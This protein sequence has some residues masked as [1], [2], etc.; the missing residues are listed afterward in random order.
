MKLFKS[1][2]FKL[3]WPKFLSIFLFILLF[4]AYINIFGFFTPGETL[5]PTCLPGVPG[6][7]VQISS[8]DLSDSVNLARLDTVN[9]FSKT[10]NLRAGSTAAGTA[11]LKF[12]SGS[13]LS[14][15]EA[16][17]IEFDGNHLYLSM[18][19]GG[20]R[21]QLDQQSGAESMVYPSPGIPVSTGAA[22]AASS[23]TDNSTNWNTAYSQTR[24]WDGGNT[25]LVPATGRT[26]LGLGTAALSAIGD[27]VS[28][29]TFGTAAGSD[30][31]AF[32]TSAQGTLANSAVQG[33]P[34]TSVGYLTSLTGAV[35]TSDIGT[36]VLA[37]RTFGS[38]AGSDIGAF[39][40]SAQGT[41][42]NSAVQGTP[43]TSE[44]YYIGD[45][46][47]FATSAQGSLANTALQSLSGA[48]LLNGN[49]NGAKK[50]LGSIDN[51][52][53]GFITNNTERLT[54]LASG[55][56]GIG[57][58]TPDSNLSI[59]T[60]GNTSVQIGFADSRGVIGY[61][62]S[63]GA[64]G[65]MYIGTGNNNGPLLLNPVGKGNVGIGTTTPTAVLQLN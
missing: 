52:D 24:Q 58:T 9:S 60:G 61:D 25:G 13:L 45:G 33:T 7:T 27:F 51:Y 54:V 46:S 3:H 31:G 55:N 23:I 59:G 41:L 18:A 8:T 19:N 44:G 35:L 1:Q 14:M 12:T 42:A 38:A 37:Q 17:S 28:Y 50:T 49:T 15:T 26:S 57:T 32:A 36:T 47:A 34:W 20:P 10:I 64:A 65:G 16:G 48:W 30:I 62:I 29:R 5:D 39:A 11:P 6:C 40:T 21:Y 2:F 22:W 53:I 43:W 56:V 63:Y 4:S